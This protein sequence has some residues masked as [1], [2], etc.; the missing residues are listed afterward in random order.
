MRYKENTRLPRRDYEQL[1]KEKELPTHLKADIC[2]QLELE[3]TPHRKEKHDLKRPFLSSLESYC[4]FFNFP[5][6]NITMVVH[7]SVV[8][9]YNQPVQQQQQFPNVQP[10]QVA[11]RFK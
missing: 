3:P 7:R 1:L 9:G 8:K 5:I 10:N 6:F 4:R 11:K 2:R